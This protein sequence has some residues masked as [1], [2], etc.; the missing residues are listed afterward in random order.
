MSHRCDASNG[1]TSTRAPAHFS[2]RGPTASRSTALLRLAP[3]PRC[4]PRTG[5]SL[6]AT[7]RGLA[8]RHEAGGDPHPTAQMAVVSIAFDGPR[9]AGSAQVCPGEAGGVERAVGRRGVRAGA[10]PRMR[11]TVDHVEDGTASLFTGPTGEPQ[12][13]TL[14]SRAPTP[15]RCAGRRPE[16]LR[17]AHRRDGGSAPSVVRQRSASH[18][19]EFRSG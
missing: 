3:G 15:W 5:A 9:S 10:E 18:G 13:S 2:R 11:T 8:A 12:P 14:P 17:D 1:I 16:A 7:H 6:R 19:R 4:A